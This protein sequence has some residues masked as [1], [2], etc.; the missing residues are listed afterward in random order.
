MHSKLPTTKS[1][2]WVALEPPKRG[3]ELQAATPAERNERWRVTIQ[4]HP[5]IDE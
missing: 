3:A 4:R 5:E 1:M 2:P